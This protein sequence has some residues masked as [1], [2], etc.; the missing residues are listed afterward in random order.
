M[1]RLSQPFPNKTASLYQSLETL[2]IHGYFGIDL[3]RPANLLDLELRELFNHCQSARKILRHHQ[4]LSVLAHTSVKDCDATDQPCT[5][6][7]IRWRLLRSPS[8]IHPEVGSSERLPLRRYCRL[9]NDG[10][11]SCLGTHP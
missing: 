3:A 2:E 7:R 9:S 4:H 1:R 11:T 6:F 8:A 10:L 5:E